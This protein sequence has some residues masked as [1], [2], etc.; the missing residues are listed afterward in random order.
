MNRLVWVLVAAYV[1]L[2]AGLF[3]CL[4]IGATDLFVLL[5]AVLLVLAVP[6]W[7]ILSRRNGRVLES[8]ST[9]QE[10]S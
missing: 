9:A 5:A 3:Y 6:Q 7:L 1:G 2:A 4:A 10:R 8:E